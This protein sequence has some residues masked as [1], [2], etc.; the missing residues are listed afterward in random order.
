M[1]KTCQ[2]LVFFGHLIELAG[3]T[4]ESGH[5]ENGEVPSRPSV[6]GTSRYRSA[7]VLREKISE[8]FG[9]LAVLLGARTLLGAPGLTTR[10]KDALGMDLWSRVCR[11]RSQMH[12]C[13]PAILQLQLR[14]SV[15]AQKPI[16]C[17]RPLAS[18]HSNR[19]KKEVT[20]GHHQEFEPPSHQQPLSKDL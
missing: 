15:M 12:R 9:L 10:S 7:P 3:Q 13:Q 6:H 1:R 17:T 14:Q 8:E 4:S 19:R 2:G 5:Q 18:K 20:Q 11:L 16:F